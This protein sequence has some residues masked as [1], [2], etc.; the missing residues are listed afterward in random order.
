MGK[1]ALF[2]ELGD[3]GV[4]MEFPSTS[5]VEQARDHLVLTDAFCGHT[6]GTIR[7]LE[8]DSVCDLVK[9]PGVPNAVR[10]VED[11]IGMGTR[12]TLLQMF[13]KFTIALEVKKNAVLIR[14]PT[15][16]PLRL[17]LDDV[18]QAAL[19]PILESINGFILHGACVV[20]GKTA[21]VFMG[22]SGAGKSTSA[23]NLT[24]F[25]YQ[26]YADDAVLI[27]VKKEGEVRVWPLNRE[28][29]IRPLSF[30]LF[31]EQGIHIG[32]YIKDGEKY[33]FNQLGEPVG[34]ARL[35]YLCFVEV[36]GESGTS[37]MPLDSETTLKTLLKEKRHFSFMARRNAS[38]YATMLAENIPTSV[39]ALVGMDMDAQARAFDRM[40]QGRFSSPPEEA[41]TLQTVVGRSR[42]IEM[43][44]RA[45]S[46]PDGEAIAAVIP[47]LG[48]CDPKV[49]SLVLAFLQTFAQAQVEPVASPSSAP[50]RFDGRTLPWLKLDQWL[51]GCRTLLHD[52]G[53]EVIARFGHTW[54]MSGP[55]LYPLLRAEARDYPHK[56]AEIDGAWERYK[57]ER[58]KRDTPPTL[59]LHMAGG[60]RQ[61]PRLNLWW[62]AFLSA[63][64]RPS[65][66]FWWVQP[67]LPPEEEAVYD[68]LTAMGRT[69]RIVLVPVVDVAANGIP[70]TMALARFLL[71]RG[72]TLGISRKTPLCLIGEEDA[73]F[74]F[75]KGIFGENDFPENENRYVLSGVENDATSPKHVLSIG[76]IPA[77]IPGVQWTEQIFPECRECAGATLGLCRGGFMKK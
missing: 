7:Y 74:I 2:L 57:Q 76:D 62:D 16:A 52:I 59:E 70:E 18:L 6:V 24:R 48:D 31:Q 69:D 75:S 56:L 3:D 53:P 35:N 1:H 12:R 9:T 5:A 72:C 64:G 39:R 58:K 41:P 67:G 8:D 21:V 17:M 11:D 15:D 47:L 68:L 13:D 19:H 42:K 26:C 50:L 14:Y 63:H 40:L 27:T 43:V 29:S 28:F 32:E 60:V 49:F 46:H 45:W 44:K 4:L 33:Y 10:I 23:F 37:I 20:K 77:Q 66:I 38:F 55:V 54:M 36:G 51:A 61:I 71:A 22:M 34:A 73:D 25:G 30:R 65:K